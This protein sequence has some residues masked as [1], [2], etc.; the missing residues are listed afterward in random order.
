[1]DEHWKKKMERDNLMSNSKINKIYQVAI[2]KGE[3]LGGKLIGAGGGGF[4]MFYTNNKVKLIKILSK[5]G[6][7]NINFAFEFSGS[8][9]LSQDVI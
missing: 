8:Q 2:K 5:Y 1:M 7:K 6:L 3:A 9:I 4:L